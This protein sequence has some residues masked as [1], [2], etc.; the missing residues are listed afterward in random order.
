MRL[1]PGYAA[2]FTYVLGEALVSN[3][4][5]RGCVIEESSR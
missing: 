3:T 4:R 2:N 1:D 5:Y